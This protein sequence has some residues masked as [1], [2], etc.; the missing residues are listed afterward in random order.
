MNPNSETVGQIK[1]AAVID[2]A[3]LKASARA[4][5]GIVAGT[6]NKSD[7]TVRQGSRSMS[8]SLE[9]VA[10][11]AG[12]V[13][14]GLLAIRSVKSFVGD[15]I[16]EANRFQ[17]ALI[18]LTS[19]AGAY[20]EDAAKAREAS[21]ELASD[22][23]MSVTD[24]ATGLKNL[25]A[26]GFS[27]DEATI[28]MNRFRDSAAFARQGSLTFGEAVRSATEGIKNGN[29]ILVDNAGVT[30]NLS[31]ILEEAGFAQNDLMRATTDSSVRQAL[32]NG[33]IKETNAQVG[34]AAK[35]SATAAGSQA[36]LG[37][38]FQLLE[39]Q[40]GRV[41]NAISMPLTNGLTTFI[42]TNQQAIVSVAS[43]VVAFGLFA[44]GA[45]LAVKAVKALITMLTLLARSPI[46]V[47]I[48]LIGI[49]V[50]FVAGGVVDSLMRQ[51]GEA[52]SGMDDMGDS[53]AAAA[54]G[55]DQMS[56][57][58]KDLQKQL[59]KIDDQIDKVNRDFR[60][61]L[62]QM[63]RDKQDQVRALTEQI[64]SENEAYSNASN[65]RIADFRVEQNKE[66]ESHSEKVARLQ[67]QIDFLRR[68]NNDSN[69]QQLS[70]LKFALAQEN[71]QYQQATT[72]RQIA[73]DA[74]LASEKAKSDARIADFTEQLSKEQSLLDRHADD[75]ASIRN[76]IL[77]DEIDNLKRSRREQL[78]SLQQQKIDAIDS[79]NKTA[80]GVGAAYDKLALSAES[81]LAAAGE[82]AGEKMGKGFAE[83]L[84]KALREG[85]TKPFTD[86]SNW[87]NDVFGIDGAFDR[88]MDDFS[89]DLYNWIYPG[90][91]DRAIPRRAKG[92]SVSAGQPYVVGDNSDGSL[93]PTSELFIPGRSGT[94]VPADDLHEAI[95]TMG[96]G[97]G[98]K[99]EI[100]ITVPLSG[101]MTRSPADERELARMLAK[102]L[103][104]VM[105]S[106]G[107]PGMEGV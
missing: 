30:K 83:M 26:S 43:G 80:A 54:G 59:E 82:A 65:E 75:V 97:S 72:D 76:V 1:Y 91:G 47:L 95:G 62:A 14:A 104:E 17:A 71:A 55:M 27:L 50:G 63:V 18:G 90:M 87:F 4:S 39:V 35:L 28:L 36:A 19:I 92:G 40:V 68:Y 5:E 25:L 67:T 89:R 99:T 6:V 37:V 98:G 88:G 64:A 52:S 61:Q 60:E 2:T 38:Q 3:Q 41:A 29:S 66:L 11:S 94:I 107:L 79:A 21:Q 86:I 7:K 8:G 49:L 57:A 42:A 73:L 56:K 53:G 45:Y 58:A 33:I 106:K 77:L 51:L 16:N 69:R 22:G 70:D 20:G 10:V 100:N 32:F 74:Q 15:S 24:A 101:I 44:G 84:S 102:R 9:G 105:R 31:V 48:T 34:D 81:N 12:L 103:N 85:L 13:V 96:G 46:G 93:N 78:I 23:L